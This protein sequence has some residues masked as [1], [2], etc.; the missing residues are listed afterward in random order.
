VR[1]DL[2]EE[3]DLQELFAVADLYTSYGDI[4]CR[5]PVDLDRRLLTRLLDRPFTMQRF[6]GA[7]RADDAESFA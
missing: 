4:A 6:S 1:L 5:V 3:I 2:V 7:C